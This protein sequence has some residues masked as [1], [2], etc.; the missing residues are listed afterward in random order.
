MNFLNTFQ[1]D[2]DID[3]PYPDMVPFDTF[4]FASSVFVIEKATNKSVPTVSFTPGKAADNFV[5]SFDV[6]TFTKN[7]FAYDSGT[8][9]VTAKVQSRW[10]RFKAERKWLARAFTLFMFLINWSLAIGSIYITLLVVLRREKMDTT[11]LLLPVTIVLIIPTL[12]S[13]FDGSPPIGI[14]IGKFW[15]LRL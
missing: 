15:A 4:S 12:R 9:K 11:V 3:Y 7:N 2:H 5:V 14:Y 8:G 10:I 13:L 1:V 6:G